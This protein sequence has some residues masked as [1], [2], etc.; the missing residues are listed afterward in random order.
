MFEADVG[1]CAITSALL[2]E[3]VGDMEMEENIFK[4]IALLVEFDSI[5]ALANS[6]RFVSHHNY[7]LTRDYNGSGTWM[8]RTNVEQIEHSMD[9]MSVQ[10]QERHMMVAK[11]K[12]FMDDAGQ[13]S[14]TM[15]KERGA[16]GAYHINTRL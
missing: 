11:P 3:C 13:D 10:S 15:R 5:I 1:G 4:W 7:V 9:K 2:V 6:H 14:R 16:Y 8:S 12:F